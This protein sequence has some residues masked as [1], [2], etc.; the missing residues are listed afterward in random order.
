FNTDTKRNL[1]AQ[2]HQ[3]LKFERTRHNYVLYPS[4]MYL[5][6]ALIQVCKKLLLPLLYIKLFISFF[7]KILP[8]IQFSIHLINIFLHIVD[9]FT[10]WIC[11]FC[12][13]LNELPDC[14]HFFIFV[15]QDALVHLPNINS[16]IKFAIII[17]IIML[18]GTSIVTILSSISFILSSFFEKKLSECLGIL[19]RRRFGAGG[20]ELLGLIGLLIS[21]VS[22][23]FRSGFSSKFVF[24]IDSKSFFSN[25]D[26]DADCNLFLNYSVLELSTTFFISSSTVFTVNSSS[27]FVVISISGSSFLTTDD[28]TLSDFF[29]AIAKSNS[30]V[31]VTS[32]PATILEGLADIIIAQ[33]KTSKFEVYMDFNDF[34]LIK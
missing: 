30:K 19:K 32:S 27:G 25:L 1:L 23:N 17:K 10:Q 18:P 3:K 26:L 12:Y 28:S 13:I 15:I 8:V 21:C 31:F 16:K 11:R 33:F 22:L 7:S 29:S 9:K 5:I 2:R 14:I 6:Q 4:D 20:L 24:S 34:I